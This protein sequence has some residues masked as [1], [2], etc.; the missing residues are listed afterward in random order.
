MYIVSSLIH[1]KVDAQSR[2]VDFFYLYFIKVCNFDIPP[3]SLAQLF[4]FIFELCEQNT[5]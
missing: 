1:R 5:L 3:M 4:I 2:F